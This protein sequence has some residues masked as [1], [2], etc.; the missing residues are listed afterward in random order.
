MLHR[1]LFKI[2]LH[3]SVRTILHVSNGIYCLS[4]E[5]H[6]LH[7]LYDLLPEFCCLLYVPVALDLFVPPQE[8]V[9]GR[10]LSA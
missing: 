4:G 9:K 1:Q 2:T 5:F 6:Y 3:F 10:E 8:A 7:L